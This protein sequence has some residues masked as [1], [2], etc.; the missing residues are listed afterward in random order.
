MTLKITS[1][2]NNNYTLIS[3]S[4]QQYLYT[5][6]FLKVEPKVKVGDYIVIKDQLLDPKYQEFSSSYIFGDLSSP[7]GRKITSNE[8][9]D[10]IKLIQGNNKKYLKR[11]YG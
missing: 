3:K 1:I 4:G 7:C 2:E 8:D 10:V 11:L 6:K 9:I 5:L